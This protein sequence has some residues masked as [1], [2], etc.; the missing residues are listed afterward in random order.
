MVDLTHSVLYV[1]AGYCMYTSRYQLLLLLGHFLK[2][3][4]RGIWFA[5]ESRV[6]VL[7]G[8]VWHGLTRQVDVCFLLGNNPSASV[9]DL[10]YSTES[11]RSGLTEEM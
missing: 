1:Q 6:S 5:V 3:R 7:A 9:P 10:Q 4:P 2:N 8:F 11:Y